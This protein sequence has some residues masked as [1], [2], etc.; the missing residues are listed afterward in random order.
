[1]FLPRLHNETATANGAYPSIVD[2]RSSISICLSG[3]V[4]AFIDLVDI[5]LRRFFLVVHPPW[6]EN[7]V[8][9]FLMSAPSRRFLLYARPA[10]LTDYD[11]HERIPILR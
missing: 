8:R 1:M 2:R 6:E 11:T 10:T 4:S 3:V 9:N 5:H 7:H